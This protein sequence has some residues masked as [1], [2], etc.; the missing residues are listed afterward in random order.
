MFIKKS[1]IVTEPGSA[2]ANQKSLP[3][4]HFMKYLNTVLLWS[5]PQDA[6]SLLMLMLLLLL[7]LSITSMQG[8]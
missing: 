5:V 1:I 8:V 6:S 4:G 7:L 2:W 3:L